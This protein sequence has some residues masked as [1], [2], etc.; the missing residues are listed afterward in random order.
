[1]PAWLPLGCGC[2]DHVK[3]VKKMN[4]VECNLIF[5]MTKDEIG[6][7]G[8][9]P[10]R[11]T[12]VEVGEGGTEVLDGLRPPARTVFP[13]CGLR[14]HPFTFGRMRGE[15]CSLRLCISPA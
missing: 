6:R 11:R 9:E 4:E 1:M 13:P 14:F 8:K 15:K 5:H 2:T 10:R 7:R 12:C 3:V